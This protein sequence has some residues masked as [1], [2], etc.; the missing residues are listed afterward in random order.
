MIVNVY[1]TKKEV[2][3]LL[4][5]EKKIIAVCTA[6]I[7]S[8]Y[9]DT[10]LDALYSLTDSFQYK[11]LFFNSFSSLFYMEK[12]DIGESN[13]FHL[14]NYDLLDGIILLS[15]TIKDE[16]VRNEIA[17]KAKSKGIPVVSIDHYIEGCFNVN[18]RYSNAMEEIITHLIEEHNYTRINFIAGQKGNSFSEE[19]LNVYKR[20]LQEHG[21]PIEEERIGYGEFWG[22]PTERVISEFLASDLPLPQAVVCANDT[23]AIATFKYLSQAGYKIPED[24]AITGFDGI[25]EALE[26][27]PAITTA[28]HDYFETVKCAF[29]IFERCFKGEKQEDQQWIDSEI[30]YGSS[31][32]CHNANEQ[33]YSVLVRDLY[34]QID[35]YNEFNHMQIKM[36]TNLIDNDSFYGVFDKLKNYAENFMTDKFW[37][38]IADDFISEKEVLSDII[39]EQNFGR[40]SFSTT[41]DIMLSCCDGEWQGLTDFRT[42]NLLPHIDR[43]FEEENNVMFLPLHVL[44]RSIGYVALVFDPS[45]MK[46]HY[47]YQFMVNIS[48]ALE[49]TRIHQRQSAIINNLENKYIHDPMTGLFNRRGF[50]QR[51]E[52]VFKSCIEENK[53][54]AVISIDLNRLKYINDTF[55]HADGDIAISTVGK[56]LSDAALNDWTCARFGG[57]EYVVAGLVKS[58]NEAK[59]F[60]DNVLAYLSDFNASSGKPYEVSASIGYVTGIP[61]EQLTLDEFIKVADEKMYEEKVRHHAQRDK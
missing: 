49:I 17:E 31:C 8:E 44:E 51:L 60:Y 15:E 52:P 6:G 46:L 26:H 45:K 4:R 42:V 27:S 53:M 10:L 19:R 37:L 61:N 54:I 47:V 56:A 28:K 39:E 50:Y 40:G 3:A 2:Y 24:I 33:K 25:R 22:G 14:I 38:C 9:I 58:E 11:L 21:I 55:G 16:S 23:M 30:L 7:N 34:D 36:T 12:H 29:E 57:D 13:I 35:S 59:D 1:I 5:E 32:G 43:I 48:N 20:V 18:F 41:M